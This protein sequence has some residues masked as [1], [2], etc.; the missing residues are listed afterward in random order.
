M[1][2]DLSPQT[3]AQLESQ[4]VAISGDIGGTKRRRY[5]TPDGREIWAV[6]AMRTYR[7]IANKKIV[8]EGLRDANL[9]RGWLLEKPTVLKPYCPA[10]DGW[11][12]TQEEVEACIAKKEAFDSK[13][14]KKAQKMKRQED[15]G[16]EV[17]KI[18]AEVSE[19]KSDMADI[20][21]MLAQ[22]LGKG[23]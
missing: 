23:E 19:I 6:P 11:H 16:E 15:G 2:R 18:K 22:L 7:K 13:W 20:K 3:R 14:A 12:D 21:N 9:D 1:A 10:C 8:D 4:G 5:W 17:D